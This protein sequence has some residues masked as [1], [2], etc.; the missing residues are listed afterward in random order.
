VEHPHALQI[1][2]G[3]VTSDD[4]LTAQM[5]RSGGQAVRLVPATASD[6]EHHTP[7]PL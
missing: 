6:R 3:L 7:L 4:V 1:R 5:G 2:R